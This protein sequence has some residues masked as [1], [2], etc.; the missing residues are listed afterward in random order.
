MDHCRALHPT[1]TGRARPMV[2][3]T[4]ALA[5]GITACGASTSDGVSTGPF[6][7]GGSGPF[8]TIDPTTPT[9]DLPADQIVWQVFSGGG[10]VP[11]AV[12]AAQVP[13]VTI[14]GDGTVLSAD[15]E[16]RDDDDHPV[17]IRRGTIPAGD[18]ASFMATVQESGL[19]DA[20][21]DFGDPQVTDLASTHVTF[22]S[23]GPIQ[24]VDVYALDHD[25]AGGGL[26]GTEQQRRRGLSSLIDTAY[27]LPGDTVPW[28]PEQVVVIEVTDRYEDPDA[29]DEPA[30]WPAAPFAS[31][32]A[33]ETPSRA[34]CAVIDGADAESVLQAAIDNPTIQFTDGSE[35]RSVVVRS[36]LPGGPAC[37]DV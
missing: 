2:A 14:Y 17:A 30:E 13:S 8:T 26:S 19:V 36:V 31:L 18:L 16:N 29:V 22:Q 25:D 6:G 20:D 10:F 11:Y 15:Y 35:T 32:Y 27:D 34:N 28:T 3:V 23:T 1:R 5:L 24:E 12:Y 33:D 4:V 37:P 9:G 7:Q 21:L